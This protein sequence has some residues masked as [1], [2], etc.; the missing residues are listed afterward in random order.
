MDARF[1]SAL[2]AV[3]ALSTAAIM[4]LVEGLGG[5]RTV[6]TVAGAVL[7]VPAAAGL[8]LLARVV[9]IAERRGARR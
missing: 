2:L 8:V 3:S 1:V 5:G 6:P 9:V 4:L 7:A